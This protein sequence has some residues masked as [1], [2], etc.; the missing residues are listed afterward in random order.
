M[1]DPQLVRRLER[2]RRLPRDLR[3][4]RRGE[5]AERLAQLRERLALDELHREVDQPVRRLAEVVD[6]G[7]V[8]DG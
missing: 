6:A 3:R 2:A 1:D 5:R 7:D 8:R 4:A